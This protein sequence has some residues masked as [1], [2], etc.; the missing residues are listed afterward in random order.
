MVVPTSYISSQ[1]EPHFWRP[2]QLKLFAHF[3][4]NIFYHLLILTHTSLHFTTFASENFLKKGNFD[5]NRL[6][7]LFHFLKKVCFEFRQTIK[8]K[9]LFVSPFF[10]NQMFG[11]EEI[12]IIW[13]KMMI[14]PTMPIRVKRCRRKGYDS[15]INTGKQGQKRKCFYSTFYV[16]P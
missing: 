2:N 1:Q 13:K 3:S 6:N 7:S 4:S 9:E 11:C 15:F 16:T 8:I 12:K 5:K 14:G 10:L